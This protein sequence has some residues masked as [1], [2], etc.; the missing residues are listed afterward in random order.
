MNIKSCRILFGCVALL[1]LAIPAFAVPDFAELAGKLKPSVVNIS[2]LKTVR[3]QRPVFPG[4]PSPYNDFFEEFFNRFFQGQ[5]T[6]H[7]ERSLGSGFIISTDGYILTNDH[8]VDDADTIKVRLSD[9]RE[10]IGKPFR[11]STPNSTSR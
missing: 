1:L 6:P 11:V 8:V 5:Q 9:G 3:P 2:T 7:E 10:F 4:Q